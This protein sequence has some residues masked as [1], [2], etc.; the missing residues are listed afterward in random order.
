MS[1][2]EKYFF[3]RIGSNKEKKYI[4]KMGTL[5][6]GLLA[7]ANYFESASGM[8]SG[9]FLKFDSL[10]PPTGFIIDPAT[11]VFALDPSF[12][13]SWQK[14]NKKEAEKILKEDLRLRETD[15]IPNDWI[16]KIS[17]PTKRQENKIEIFNIMSAYR[18]L[19][20]SY[21]DNDIASLVGKQALTKNNFT[22]SS[23]NNFVKNVIS[24]QD[25]AITSRYNTAKYSGFYDVVAKPIVVLSPYF[26][27]SNLEDFEFMVE[28]WKSF[29]SQYRK[30]NGAIVLQ[31]TI[32]FLRDQSQLLLENLSSI[33]KNIL[34]LWIDGFDEVDALPEQ[35]EAYVRFIVNTSSNGKQLINLYTGGLSPLLF[36]FGLSGMVNNVGYG[37]QREAEPVKGGI[38]TAQFYIP[39]LHVREQVLASYDL[40]I[41]NKVGTTKE[42]FY[43]DICSCPICKEGIKNGV[44]DFIPFYGSVGLPKSNPES[45]KKYPTPIAL[46]R[47]TFHFLLSRLREYKWAR[48]SQ[49]KDVIGRLNEEITIWHKNKDHLERLLVILQNI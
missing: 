23:L 45:T 12:I 22:A 46:N 42:L 21:F 25:N 28:I 24:Y 48:T 35:L 3:L 37:M 27:I 18:K 49:K 47:C 10:K 17:N 43:R 34:F 7:R 41:K 29:D 2:N 5:F 44:K 4:K 8:L 19:A 40:F 9:I 13:R 20:D 1:N 32:D 38:P 36:P 6:S 26:R 31:C 39:T 11:Y 33:R 30:E 15:R 16:R 14:V